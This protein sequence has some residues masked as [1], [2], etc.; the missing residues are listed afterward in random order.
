MNIIIIT[1][2]TCTGKT[3]LSNKIAE[4]FKDTIIIKTDSYYR[5]NLYIKLLSTF[6]N[7][8]YDRLISIKSRELM[9]TINSIYN[10]KKSVLF[11]NYD[12]RTRHSSILSRPITY[13]NKSRFVILEGVF[14]HRLN[15]DYKKTINI[16]CKE[17]KELCYQRRLKR[18]KTERAR[19]TKE[20]NNRF[21]KS[22]SLY[23]KNVNKFT[24]DNE[25][26]YINQSK[27]ESFNNL[28]KTLKT[29]KI[30]N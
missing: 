15:L 30:K 16:I 11:Y 21:S 17:N 28:L 9:N 8:I 14:A 18:D 25:I 29:I 2:P 7:D 1:G 22:W 12:F 27:K 19:N 23:F 10:K 6:I 4:I 13:N 5:D 26:I 20:V 3:I 24:N